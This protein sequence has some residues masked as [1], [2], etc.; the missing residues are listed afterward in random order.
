LVG[1]ISGMLI[2]ISLYLSSNFPYVCISH[3]MSL[4][5][6]LQSCHS[7]RTIASKTLH[8]VQVSPHIGTP[9][10]QSKFA[11]VTQS[12]NMCLIHEAGPWLLPLASVPWVEPLPKHISPTITGA[13]KDSC[14][15]PKV[16][17]LFFSTIH[18]VLCYS[19]FLWQKG[20][21]FL[22]LLYYVFNKLWQK[23]NL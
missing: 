4:Q 6:F 19:F 1:E 9:K 5:F 16:K 17:I 13:N 22:F 14:P 23:P 8:V 11:F 20:G 21:C 3:Y 12:S 10:S 15:L 18:N 7:T 2:T